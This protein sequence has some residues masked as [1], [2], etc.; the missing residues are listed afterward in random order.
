MRVIALFAIF[1]VA[2]CSTPSDQPEA[3]S[4]TADSAPAIADSAHNSRNAL[5]WPGTYSGTLPCADCEG[6]KTT[7]K[8]NAD[9]TFERELVY[10]GETGEPVRQ[11]GS[12]SWNDAGSIVTLAPGDGTTQKYQVGENQLFHLDQA[13]NRIGGELA[14]RYVLR[15]SVH[16]PRIENRKWLLIEVMGRPYAPSEEGREAFIFFDRAES[17]GSGNTSCNNFFGAY[18]IEAGQR[19]R[20][21]GNVG[22]T[23]MA[24]PDMSVEKAFLEALRKVDNYTVSDGRLSLNRARMAPLLRFELAPQA[25]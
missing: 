17:R 22:A 19:I 13:G 1:L 14:D 2:A 9:G 11:A 25:D 4:N 5:D 6:I 3:A 10:L 18:V 8:L 16:D 20:F 15:Q 23:M 12:F 24:C 21:T 7:V